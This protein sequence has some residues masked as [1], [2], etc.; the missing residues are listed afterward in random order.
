[1]TT[2][3]PVTDPTWATDAAFAA[4]PQVGMPPRLDPGALRT[5]G[6]YRGQ[7][8]PARH[9]NHALGALGDW[10]QYQ[11]RLATH[12]AMQTWDQVALP[13][14][15]AS[16]SCVFQF[17][18]TAPLTGL[19][20]KAVIAIGYDANS[21]NCLVYMRS[22]GGGFFE[23]S[24]QSATPTAGPVCAASGVAGE[25][26]TSNAAVAVSHTGLRTKVTQALNGHVYYIP[27]A[28]NPYIGVDFSAVR[29]IYGNTFPNITLN[30]VAV[31]GL[32]AL[33]ASTLGVPGGM[34]ADD[35]AG[36]VVYSTICTVSSSTAMR[37]FHSGDGGLSWQVTLTIS[38]TALNIVWSAVDNQFFAVAQDGRIFTSPTGVN[39]TNTRTITVAGLPARYGT[40]A[41]VGNCIATAIIPTVFGYF[42]AAGVAY[43]LDQGVTWRVQYLT[44][45]SAFDGSG[46]PI[47]SLIAANNR[48]YATEGVRVFRSGLMLF[49]NQD[50]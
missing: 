48:F 26:L 4:G 41:V 18:T 9:F 27:W 47:F 19:K 31:S 16:R 29:F 33:T 23:T 10:A 32:T 34:F 17:L 39:W 15:A 8:P 35:G 14:T 49:E 43:T 42:G 50:Y 45:A 40:L 13:V 25:F 38:T 7:R 46:S 11:D 28:A 21:S 36:H 12:D 24:V 1:M 30:A 20:E 22:W 44:D 37:V 2:N 6:Y 5:Q 3:R